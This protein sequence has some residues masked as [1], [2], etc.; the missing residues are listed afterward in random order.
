MGFGDGF[1]EGGVG[2]VGGEVDFVDGFVVVDDSELV[3]LVF[4]DF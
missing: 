1:D 3:G 2:G 4:G